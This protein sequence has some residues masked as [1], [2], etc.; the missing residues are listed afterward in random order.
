MDKELNEAIMFRSKLRHKYLKFKSVIDKQRYN[1]QRNYYIK[2][3]RFKKQKYQESLDISKITDNKT[4]WKATSN[5]SSKKSYS[6]NS[7]ITILKNGDIFSEKPKVA[8]TFNERFSNA[9]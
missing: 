5:S 8:D 2:L 1:K 6:A 7:R 9:I 3:L 4:F